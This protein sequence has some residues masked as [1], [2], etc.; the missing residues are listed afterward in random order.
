MLF[1]LLVKLWA[2]KNNIINSASPKDGL[3]GYGVVLMCLYYLM[4]S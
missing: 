4:E 1:V 2:K 3:S